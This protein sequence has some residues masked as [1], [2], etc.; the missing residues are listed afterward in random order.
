[1]LSLCTRFN[2]QFIFKQNKSHGLLCTTA[3]C[4]R[5]LF[6]CRLLV[7]ASGKWH[8]TQQRS[9]FTP[10]SCSFWRAAPNQKR[11]LNKVK[12]ENWHKLA[13]HSVW[14]SL[15][16]SYNQPERRLSLTVSQVNFNFK[17]HHHETLP[18]KASG[19]SLALEREAQSETKELI[20]FAEFLC[21]PCLSFLCYK[22]STDT[23]RGKVWSLSN[24]LSSQTSR[25]ESTTICRI[26]SRSLVWRPGRY[27]CY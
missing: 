20:C 1:M 7:C 13:S 12:K 2:M 5:C 11:L 17:D 10:C 22:S 26:I 23:H 3:F 21:W 4:T 16:P 18:I 6:H 25:S 8:P 19:P 14:S 24:D 15:H 9:H 27:S